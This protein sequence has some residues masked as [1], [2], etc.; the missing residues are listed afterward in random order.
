MNISVIMDSDLSL[1]KGVISMS[2]RR[3]YKVNLNRASAEELFRGIPGIRRDKID[4][5]IKKDYFVF[6][7]DAKGVDSIVQK[8][9]QKKT[10]QS[11]P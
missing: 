10:V 5:I 4:N 7:G 1:M 2:D 9:L 3:S 6:I 8:Y 11:F